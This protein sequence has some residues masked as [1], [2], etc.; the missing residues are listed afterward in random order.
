M[1]HIL[2]VT[3]WKMEGYAGL[4]AIEFWQGDGETSWSRRHYPVNLKRWMPPV[5]GIKLYAQCN[6]TDPPDERRM[7]GF[8]CKMQDDMEMSKLDEARANLKRLARVERKYRA[9]C[10]QLGYPETF[11]QYAG[12]IASC[13]GA[14]L[15][16]W[17]ESSRSY[18][19]AAVE[20][21]RLLE[22]KQLGKE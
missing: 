19:F 21:V 1:K 20:D 14:D 13:I 2:A 16:I 7:Y 6:L 11:A 8:S 10:D 4:E 18:E 3:T 15:A 9:M 17:R 5:N 12:Y 22:R